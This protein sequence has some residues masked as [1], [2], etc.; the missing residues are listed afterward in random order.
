MTSLVSLISPV[1]GTLLYTFTWTCAGSIQATSKVFSCNLEMH[2]SMK[3]SYRLKL[4]IWL[5]RLYGD[6]T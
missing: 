3:R 2:L 4:L 5:R 6:V 1:D